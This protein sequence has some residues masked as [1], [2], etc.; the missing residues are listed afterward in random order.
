MPLIGA[1]LLAAIGIGFGFLLL[2]APGLYLLAVWA[3]TAPAVVIER[4]GV[5]DALGR[6][7]QLVRGNG[8]PVLG[9]FLVAIAIGIVFGIGLVAAA[10]AL[11]E[12]KILEVVFYALASTVTAP[13]EALVAAVLYFRLL[14]IEQPA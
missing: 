1:S 5:F 4:R 12:G 2:I 3:V 8:W 10:E 9:V 7:R 11:A 6:S 13:I 14:E